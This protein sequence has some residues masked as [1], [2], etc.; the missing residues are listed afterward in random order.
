M[1]CEKK[2][3]IPEKQIE[4][5]LKYFDKNASLKK[6]E[7]QIIINYHTEG[8]LRLI[9]TNEYSKLDYQDNQNKNEVYITKKYSEELIKMFSNIGI[10]IDF[11]RYRT[12]FRYKYKDFYITID[13]NYKT[14]NIIR[15]K[16]EVED[17]NTFNNEI[18]EILNTLLLSD[19]SIDK[20]E[21]IYGKYRSDWAE[22]TKNINELDFLEDKFKF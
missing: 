22:L 13:H 16:K 2:I 19:T 8:D 10:S 4:S 7:R 17:K 21:E 15:F 18:T 9:V 11:K 12:R 14:G 20:F 3:I 5:V 1:I 6:E